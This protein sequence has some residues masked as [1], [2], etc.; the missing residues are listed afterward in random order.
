[1]TNYMWRFYYGYVKIVIKGGGLDKLLAELSEE[2]AA[3]SRVRRVSHTV[4]ELTVPS[5]QVWDVLVQAAEY[6]C[7]AQTAGWK[8]LPAVLR[9]IVSH[10]GFVIGLAAAVAAVFFI[11]GFVYTVDIVGARDAEQRSR[12]L[13]V[14]EENGYRPVVWRRNIDQD[15]LELLLMSEIGDLAFVGSEVFGARMTVRVVQATEQLE[16]VDRSVPC[17]IVADREGL[18]TSINVYCGTPEVETGDYVYP[19]DVL[20]SGIVQLNEESSRAVHALADIS[21]KAFFAAEGS[22][23]LSQQVSLKTGQ[24]ITKYDIE[25]LGVKFTF[26][27]WKNVPQENLLEQKRIV[28]SAVLNVTKNKYHQVQ[29][30][31]VDY[32]FEAAFSQAERRALEALNVQLGERTAQEI[33]TEYTIT[34]Q[35]ILKV[36]ASA[37]VQSDIGV[38]TAWDE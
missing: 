34:Q 38:K 28:K 4:M 30:C 27:W 22:S 16:T 11:S 37:W 17:D 9:E 12:I 25:L 26:P 20:V 31:R 35:N 1:M 18:I 6:G 36:R 33:T 15:R 10:L 14:M 24:S 29:R 8:G 13:S 2:G 5:S 32:P 3:L 19:G 23:E 7:Q 21:A